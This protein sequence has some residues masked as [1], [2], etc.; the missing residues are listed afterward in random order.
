M[1]PIV[2]AVSSLRIALVIFLVFIVILFF[3]VVLVFLFIIFFLVWFFSKEGI[4]GD[5]ATKGFW[6]EVFWT[7]SDHVQWYASNRD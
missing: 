4:G 1:T 6:G 5:K 3:A 7:Q 2:P